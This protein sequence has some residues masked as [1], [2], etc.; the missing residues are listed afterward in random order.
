MAAKDIRHHLDHLRT[1]EGPDLL[2]G[3]LDLFD[4]DDLEI[5]I[6]EILLDDR[7]GDGIVAGAD[8]APSAERPHRADLVHPRREDRDVVFVLPPLYDPLLAGMAVQHEGRRAFGMDEID[9]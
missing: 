3:R 5:G 8:D 2:P 6:A 9:L 1:G 7:A 4:G